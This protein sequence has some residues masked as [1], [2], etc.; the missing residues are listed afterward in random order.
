MI[1]K[2][3][4]KFD[5]DS[6]KVY[7]LLLV[8]LVVGVGGFFVLG[9]ITALIVLAVCLYVAYLI[10]KVLAKTLS[11]RITTYTDGFTVR[12]ADGN[13][14]DFEWDLLSYAG[15]VTE[16]I[17]K[18]YTFVYEESVDRFVQLPPSFENM[19]GFRAEIEEHCHV[20]DCV[21]KPSETI[22]ERIKSI[23]VTEPEEAR[24]DE[25]T[26]DADEPNAIEHEEAPAE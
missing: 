9:K 20:E 6:I 23:F 1:Y 10:L 22:K 11:A 3:K 18:G 24:A 26:G 21:M 2:Y 19:E 12:M 15:Y 4:M 5:G 17:Q 13:K 16:G 25:N 14:I 8:C 7:L